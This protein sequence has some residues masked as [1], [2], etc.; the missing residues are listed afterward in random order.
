MHLASVSWLHPKETHFGAK[1]ADA[2]FANR[3][4]TL[5]FKKMYFQSSKPI[6]PG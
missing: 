6:H 5:I 4:K 3:H 1:L 2:A